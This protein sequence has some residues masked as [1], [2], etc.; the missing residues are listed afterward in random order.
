M[1]V[2][3]ECVRYCQSDDVRVM[4]SEGWSQRDDV[5]VTI[6]ESWCKRDDVSVTI[7]A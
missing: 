4:E 2:S 6:P 5:R 1:G 3:E 7:Y